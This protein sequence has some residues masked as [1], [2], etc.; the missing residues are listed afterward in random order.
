MVEYWWKL[1]K[2][3]S[4]YFSNKYIFVNLIPFDISQKTSHAQIVFV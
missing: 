4:F 1:T 3:V 2:V